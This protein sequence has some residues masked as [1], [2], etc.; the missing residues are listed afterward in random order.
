MARRRAQETA[1]SAADRAEDGVLDRVR[2]VARGQR[3]G[4]AVLVAGGLHAAE[5]R[6]MVWREIKNPGR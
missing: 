2:E 5:D 3:G 4:H 1:R 6:H